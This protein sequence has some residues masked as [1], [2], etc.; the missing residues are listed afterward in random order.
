MVISVRYAQNDSFGCLLPETCSIVTTQQAVTN[1]LEM[2]MYGGVSVVE[3]SPDR[4]PSHW[5]GE[6]KGHICLTARRTPKYAIGASPRSR[7]VDGTSA[8]VEHAG[9]GNK[10]H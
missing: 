2:S 1:F 6:C 9:S 7:A 10:C 8:S 3:K 4:I 5:V